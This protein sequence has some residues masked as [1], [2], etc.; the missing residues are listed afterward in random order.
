MQRFIYWQYIKQS[1]LKETIS[2]VA[3]FQCSELKSSVQGVA[4]EMLD[5]IDLKPNFAIILSG[6]RRCGKSTLLRQLLDKTKKFYYFNFEDPR[7]FDFTIADFEK[8]EEI[9]REEFNETDYYFFDE[10]QNIMGWE[11]FVRMKL[12]QGKKIIVTGSN[13]SLLSKELGT[14][15]TGRHLSYE[16]FPFSYEEML[17]FRNETP[18]LN[19]FEYYFKKGGFPQFLKEDRI[20]IMHELLKDI[21]LRDIVARYG[22]K[23]VK[24]LKELAVYLLTNV[25]REFSYNKL[26]KYFGVKSVNSV[27]SYVSYLEDSYLI[28]TISKFDYSYKKQ[29]VNPKKVYSI[30]VGLSNSNSVSFSEDKGSVLENLVFLH[31]RR[32]YKEIYYFKGKQECDFLVRDRGKLILAIQV[33]YKVTED[34]KERELKGLKEAMETLKINNGMIITFNQEDK[35]DNI[36][37]MPAWRWMTEGW[38]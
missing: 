4:R 27:T 37:L 34:N 32:K 15:L 23:E 17:K 18:S 24:T 36:K 6:I 35:L 30:D 9:F 31:L 38:I 28:F 29:L 5:E 19:S 14:R 7:V 26:A 20:E 25:G 12:D 3:K 11:R 10:I 16:L 21:L 33:C 8:L 1:M 22:L 2:E 13:A